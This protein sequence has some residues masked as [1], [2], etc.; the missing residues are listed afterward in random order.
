[1]MEDVT[2][3]KDDVSYV[4]VYKLSRF[5]R[6]AADV[7][8]SLQLLMDYEVDLVSVDDAIDSSTQGG[9]LT[10]AILSAV[11]EIERE[12]ITV[13]FL[14]GKMQKLKGGG[15]PGGPIPY[16]YRKENGGLVQY[17]Q[18]TEIVKL[19]FDMYLQDDVLATTIVRYL[20]DNGYTR[21]IKGKVS[22]FKYDFVTTVLD[23]SVYCGKIFY[24]R[25]TNSK[26]PQKQ[27]REVLE[28]QGKHKPIISV[29]QWQQVQQKRM[30]L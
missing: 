8:K 29:E 13:Q 9:R 3:Q 21:V 18:E 24:G 11:A 20:N 22:P 14:S 17:P 12:N 5:G 6:N 2:S 19:I 25:R 30:S 26:E 1:M 16:G 7:L 15:W 4:L 28:V 23:N 27:K 10:L